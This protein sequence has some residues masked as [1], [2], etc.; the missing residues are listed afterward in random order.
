MTHAYES[1]LK[2]VLDFCRKF[3]KAQ[4]IGHGSP[5][6]AHSLGHLLLGEVALLYEPLVA[7]CGLY[8]VEVFSLDVLNYGH[9]QHSLLVGLPDVGGDHIH[10]GKPAG[11]PAAFS[12]NYLIPA[13]VQAS[14][15][16]W[17]YEAE[18]LY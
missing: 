9:F 17:L 18:S 2:V 8:G 12:A 5:F 10:A 1:Y 4:V 16:D 3:E 13:V 11:A 7:H 6:L 15:G 14:H